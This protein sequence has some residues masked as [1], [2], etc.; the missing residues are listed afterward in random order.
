MKM[1][2]GTCQQGRK[3][4]NCNYDETDEI[5]TSLIKRVVAVVVIFSCL[6]AYMM[7]SA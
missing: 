7:V 4:C 5:Y 6:F 3:E 2:N 1:Y